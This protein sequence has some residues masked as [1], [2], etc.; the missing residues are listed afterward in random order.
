MDEPEAE[1]GPAR[2][3]GGDSEG[4]HCLPAKPHHAHTDR[5]NLVRCQPENN[6]VQVCGVVFAENV[7]PRASRTSWGGRWPPGTGRCLSMPTWP[8]LWFRRHLWAKNNVILL[9]CA[10]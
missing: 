4:L 2:L 1:Q 10:V 9:F 5:T 7:N 6:V 3:V 8:G